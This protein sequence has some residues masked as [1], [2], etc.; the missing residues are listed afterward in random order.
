MI[1]T[2]PF[3]TSTL[4]ILK[5][6]ITSSKFENPQADGTISIPKEVILL[7]LNYF[8]I[9]LRSRRVLVS[10]KLFFP[11]LVGDNHSSG[12]SNFTSFLSKVSIFQ[13]MSSIEILSYQIL[14]KSIKAPKL[15]LQL[16]IKYRIA[17][18]TNILS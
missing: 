15:K 13:Q 17:V 4:L 11:F 3:A 7:A 14:H 5:I 9:S 16:Q 8:A 1:Y 12:C 18:L 6:K 10:V 2:I